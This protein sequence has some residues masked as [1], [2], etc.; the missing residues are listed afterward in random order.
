ML[1]S[2]QGCNKPV[3]VTGQLRKVKIKGILMG[4]CIDC[5]RKLLEERKAKLNYG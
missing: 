5:R 3:S 2:C 4:L 1:H